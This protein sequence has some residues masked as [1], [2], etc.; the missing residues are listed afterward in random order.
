MQ[1]ISAKNLRK[2][3]LKFILLDGEAALNYFIEW[4]KQII[5]DDLDFQSFKLLSAVYPKLLKNNFQSRLFSRIKSAYRRTWAENQL[6]LN[7]LNELFSIL[8]TAEIKFII[9]DENIRIPEIYSDFGIFSLQ[10]FS[11]ITPLSSKNY[12]CQKLSENDWGICGEEI[13]Q[14]Q[15]FKNKSLHIKVLWISDEVFSIHL[16]NVERVLVKAKLQP[17]MCREEQIL[18]LCTNELLMVNG[19]ESRWQFIVSA[20]FKYQKINANRLVELARR[21]HLAHQLAKMLQKLTDDFGIGIP[22]NLIDDLKKSPK[23]GKIALIS[24][25]IQNLRQSYQLFSKY[26]KISF[27]E[28]LAERWKRDSY[29]ALFKHVLQ[30]GRRLLQTK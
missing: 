13:G 5:Y 8:N 28:F 6:L 26:E 11:I 15:V 29:K 3:L 22:V 4:E 2:L 14:M 9:A 23:V 27:L 17:I 1:S 16:K 10:N 21:K 12:V 25:K 7:Y 30:S 20:L 18:N 24:Q 19:G